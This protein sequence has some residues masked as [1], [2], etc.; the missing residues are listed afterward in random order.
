MCVKCGLSHYQKNAR[1]HAAER[2]VIYVNPATGER[3]TPMRADVDMPEPYKQQGFERVEIDSILKFERETG[4]IH[5][6][7]NYAP[8]NEPDPIPDIQYTPP[9]EAV[10]VVAED[11]AAAVASGPWTGREKLGL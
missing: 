2:A 1:V 8:G 4:L 3:R 5:E 11:I 7:S 9:P 6:A 10:R